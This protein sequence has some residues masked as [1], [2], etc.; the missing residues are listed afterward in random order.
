MTR[1]TTEKVK[2]KGK[3][4]DKVKGR[5]QRPYPSPS[6]RRLQL[7]SDFMAKRSLVVRKLDGELLILD[8]R[9][10]RIHQLNTTAALVWNEARKGEHAEG[11]AMRLVSRFDI[12]RQTAITDSMQALGDLNRLQLLEFQAQ[13]A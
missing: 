6:R 7:L 13:A 2:G 8:L 10:N 5:V 3:V 11:I 12:D 9:L 4:K 1:G